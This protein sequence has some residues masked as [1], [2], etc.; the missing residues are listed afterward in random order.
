LPEGDGRPLERADVGAGVPGVLEPPLRLAFEQG[1]QSYGPIPFPFE[2]FAARALDRL[3]ARLDAQGNPST[4]AQLS[5]QLE[6]VV[7]ADLFLALACDEGIEEAWQCLCSRF[8]TRLAGLAR[9]RG[10]HRGRDEELVRDAI[11][12]LRERVGGPG[13]RTRFSNYVGAVSLSS[14]LAVVLLRRMAD[15]RRSPGRVFA[16][17]DPEARTPSA[18]T[19]R[20]SRAAAP[21]ADPALQLIDAET[22]ELTTRALEAAWRSLSLREREVVCLRYRDGI[23][24][25]AIARMLG[26]G[27]SMLSRMLQRA[28]ERIRASVVE[29][30]SA[31]GSGIAALRETSWDVLRD[32]VTKLLQSSA[33]KRD[34][35]PKGPHRD[36]P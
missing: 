7:G 20:P 31:G 8:V 10:A 28:V 18:S 2:R 4:D 27:E 23:Q 15:A 33:P 1:V 21:E 30:F 6:R 16:S 22:R 19:G 9:R 3:R 11:A 17:I 26:I 24:Q 32:S 34:S 35:P 29:E 25:K 5:R 13:G 14:W 12:D 36:G